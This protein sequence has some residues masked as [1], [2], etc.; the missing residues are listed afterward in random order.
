MAN[1]IV[2]I[3]KDLEIAAEDV[4]HWAATAEAIV[5]KATPGV[6]AA[7]AVLAVGVEKAAKDVST[8]VSNPLGLLIA[9][10]QQLQDFIAVWPEVKKFLASIGITKL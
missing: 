9:G 10:P 2:T 6:L 8:D 3:G 1:V 5:T 7:L 4:L